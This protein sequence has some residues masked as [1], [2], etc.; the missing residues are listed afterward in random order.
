MACSVE[1]SVEATILAGQ[2]DVGN[3]IDDN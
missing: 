1:K 2:I 3:R